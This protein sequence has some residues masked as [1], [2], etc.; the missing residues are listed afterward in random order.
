MESSA[1]MTVLTTFQINLVNIDSGCSRSRR[2]F[3]IVFFSEEIRCRICPKIKIGNKQ[4][5]TL[6]RV[7]RC[8]EK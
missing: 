6:S 1:S 5:E 3:Y 4:E 8:T 2:N 7:P